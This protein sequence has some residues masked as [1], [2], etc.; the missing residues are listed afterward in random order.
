[1]LKER[2]FS[3]ERQPVLPFNAAY[4]AMNQL[5]DQRETRNPMQMEL[6]PPVQPDLFIDSTTPAEPETATGAAPLG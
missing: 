6:L 5:D 4:R 2:Q 1:M 3:D